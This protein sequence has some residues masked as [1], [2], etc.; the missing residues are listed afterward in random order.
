MKIVVTGTGGQVVTSLVEVAA[1]MP[2]VDL[3]TFGLPEFDLSDPSSIRQA[4]PC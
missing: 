3:S 4:I 2:D 1:S